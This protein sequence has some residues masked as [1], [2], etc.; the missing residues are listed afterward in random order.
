[1]LPGLG[2]VPNLVPEALHPWGQALR[3][4]GE[5]AQVLM[6]GLTVNKTGADSK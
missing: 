2:H 1:M 3:L 4:A 6:R 5:P